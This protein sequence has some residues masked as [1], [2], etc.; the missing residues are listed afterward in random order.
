M[1]MPLSD[2]TEAQIVEAV[3]RFEQ[4]EMSLCME[5][6]TVRLQGDTLFVTLEG[7]TFPAEKA[8]A[9]NERGEGLMERYHSRLYGASRSSLEAEIEALLGRRV[10]R[11]ALRVD[12]LSGTGTIQFALGDSLRK[13]QTG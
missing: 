7:L 2:P 6:V 9:Q 4:N 12:P 10:R 3:V 11:S 8:C 1:R 5:S 13:G